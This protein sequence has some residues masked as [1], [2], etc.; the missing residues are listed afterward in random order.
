MPADDA[1]VS[2]TPGSRWSPL[3]NQWLW[4][5]AIAWTAVIVGL[6]ALEFHQRYA[7]KLAEARAEADLGWQ[8]DMV[9][10]TWVQSHGGVYVPVSPLS[11]P[12]PN[13]AH[14]PERDL[15]TPS[16]KALTLVNSSYLFRQL[17]EM[18]GKDTA[19]SRTSSL[20][21]LRP[22]NA[23]TPREAQALRQF[24]AG[25]TEAAWFED[26]GTQRVLRVMRPFYVDAKCLKCHAQQGYHLGD[27]R[28]GITTTVPVE[29]FSGL[30]AD[31]RSLFAGFGTLWITGLAGLALAGRSLRRLGARQQRAQLALRKSEEKYKEMAELLPEGLFECDL[32][33]R[34]LYA[35]CQILRE[36]AL[37]HA[38]IDA[39]LNVAECV[40]PED[41]PRAQANIQRIA[42]GAQREAIEY[43]ALRNDGTRF[44]MVVYSSPIVRDGQPV[45][46]RAIVVNIT[47]QKQ[48][49]E[50]LLTAASID[51]L[52]G[53]ANRETLLDHLQHAVERSRSGG[54]PH[55][56]VLFLDFDHFKV[57]NDS[58]GHGAGDELL[59]EISR[60]LSS[61]VRHGVD[62]VAPLPQSPVAAR[63]GGDEFVILLTTLDSDRQ[64]LHIAERLLETLAV[65]YEIGPRRIVSTA[66]IGLVMG[67]PS[68]PQAQDVLRDADTAMY[69]AKVRGRGRVVLFDQSMRDR[70]RRRLEIETD[71]RSALAA[72]QLEL[73]YQ[74]IVSLETGLVESYEA[75]ARWRHP[76][77]GFISPAEFIPLAEDCGLILPFGQWAFQ[78]ACRQLAAFRRLTPAPLVPTLGVNLSRRQI[79]L[80]DLPQ[81]LVRM[82]RDEGIQPGDIMLEITESAVMSDV[83][84]AS[85][86]IRQIK[87]AGFL[88]ALDDFGTGYSSLGSLH[89]FP[90]DVLKIDRSF[91]ANLERGRHYTALVQSISA[92][93]SNLNMRVVAEGVETESQVSM[94]QSLECTCAQGFLFARPMPAA[95][96]PAYRPPP[97]LTPAQIKI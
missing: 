12:N 15:T 55:Y 21:P 19:V 95:Q 83:A 24:E 8:R 40:I 1:P 26:D 44:D 23:P 14:V 88:V 71:L 64:A 13:L 58:L 82:A 89:Q 92:L 46:V 68:Y 76:Q 94:L 87:D 79:V 18:A 73:Y 52:T 48:L 25:A 90:I 28:G 63:L 57:V 17:R 30:L 50:Q 74:P 16:G 47:P 69:E 80:P 51:R 33:G 78:T 9:Y 91:I 43:T 86:V 34:V 11:P 29:T 66:S 6:L 65:P 93:A 35:N 60:R 5:F 31:D 84:T 61:Q 7:R 97:I 85:R 4:A 42:S 77:H 54:Q 70:A 56:A 36:F 2:R 49:E 32:T 20:R 81:Q 10:R 3:L 37:T 39:G 38:H 41:R 67:H 45:G 22:E 59:V 72:D 53:L 75:L 27:V 96:V 62:L